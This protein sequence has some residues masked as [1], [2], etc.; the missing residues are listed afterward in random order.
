VSVLLLEAGGSD[1]LMFVKAPAAAFKLQNDDLVDWRYRTT[2]QLH[3]SKANTKEQSAW[4][5]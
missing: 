2:T 5:R 1:E 4:P 3:A